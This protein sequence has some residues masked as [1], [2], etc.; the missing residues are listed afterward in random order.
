MKLIIDALKPVKEALLAVSENVGMYEAVDATATHIIYAPDGEAGELALD[1]AKTGQV[2]QGTIDLFAQNKDQGMADSVQHALR[3]AGI[4]FRLESVQYED[5]N[6][7]DFVHY[8]WV[9][10]VA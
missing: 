8:E 3:A 4:S 2:I 7:N 10:E 1:N 6:K 9:F 5:L